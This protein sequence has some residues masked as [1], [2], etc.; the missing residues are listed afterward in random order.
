MWNKNY[1]DELNGHELIVDFD[2]LKANGLD[3]T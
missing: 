1:D 3:L 2:K